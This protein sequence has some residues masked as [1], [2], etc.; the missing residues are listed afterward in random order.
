[1]KSALVTDESGLHYVREP[2]DSARQKCGTDQ[3]CDDPGVVEL[4]SPHGLRKLPDY[5]CPDPK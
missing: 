3:D 2:S 4:R 1:L 5:Y